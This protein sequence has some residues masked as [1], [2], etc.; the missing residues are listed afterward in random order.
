MRWGVVTFPGSNDDHDALYALDRVLGEDAV[1]LCTRSA[2]S[3]APMHHSSR[4]VLVRRLSA[5]RRHGAFL[6][7]DG[8]HRR[9][10]PAGGLVWGICNGFQ[11]LC[12]AGCCPARWFATAPALH[13]HARQRARRATRP[14][15]TK[16]VHTGEV[17]TIHQARPRCYV[18]E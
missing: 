9:V 13:L 6:T 7:G 17:L 5:L 4:R 1:P 10:R 2:T 14:R 12:E 8:Q 3:K 11:V 16:P 18:A 15:F